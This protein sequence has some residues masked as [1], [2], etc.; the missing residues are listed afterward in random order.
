[1]SNDKGTSYWFS[2][3]LFFFT[4]CAFASS[5]LALPTKLS[6]RPT[7]E[8]LGY[9]LA[10]S[11]SPEAPQPIALA[12][13]ADRAEELDQL[14][15]QIRNQLLTADELLE[16]E[17]QTDSNEH[18]IVDRS[19]QTRELL[20]GAA[21]SLKLEDEQRYWRSKSQHFSSQRKD[22]TARAA[23]LQ[24]QIQLLET[25]QSEWQMTWEQIRNVQGIQA[26]ADRAHQ[27]LEKAQSARS[28][29]Q[30]QLNVVLTLQNRV[31]LEDQQVAEI[32]FRVRQ[33]RDR[34]RQ[35]IFQPD[36]A[37]LWRAS[38][39]ETNAYDSEPYG[40][41][42]GSL[43]SASE[44][45]RTH[46]LATIGVV[47][48]YLLALSA[49]IALRRYILK[50]NA[51][52][53]SLELLELL[54][55]PYS[56]AVLL[57]LIVTGGYVTSAP[58]SIAFFFYLLYA[59]PVL[60]LLPRMTRP[61]L[62]LSIY[63]T[64]CFYTLG[65]LYLLVQLPPFVSRIFYA[66]LIASAIATLLKISRPPLV[67][68]SLRGSHWL[69][70]LTLC[71]YVEF[72]ILIA[73]L[74]AN[75]AGLFSLS[76]LLG[77][78]ALVGPFFGASLY[79]AARVVI[80]IAAVVIDSPLVLM[81][82]QIH[83]SSAKWWSERI[84]AAVAV[85]VWFKSILQLLTVYEGATGTAVQLLKRPIGFEKMHF[86]VGSIFGIVV[87]MIGGY[88][89][90]K[91]A[92]LLLQT[93]VLP[94]VPLQRG[95]PYAIARITYY[96]LLLMVALFALSAAGAEL[97]KFTVLTGAMG[98]GLGFGL[99]NIVN[100][101]VSGIILLCERPIHVGDTVEIAGLVGVVRRIGARSSTILTFQG[102]E[103]IVPN[104][105]LLSDQVINWTLS[106][107]LR[108]VDIKVGVAYST[109]PEKVIKL[110]AD[111]ANS[112]PG[113]LMERPPAAFFMGFGENA[114]NFE[115]RFWCS[116]QDTWFQLQSDVT[117][118]VAKALGEAGIEIPFPQRDLH[119]RD[120]GFKG[121]PRPATAGARWPDLPDTHGETIH[122]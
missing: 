102:A 49:V 32:L 85:F 17:E 64:A 116:R 2:A 7:T 97:N 38:K 65:A 121:G 88:A 44:F 81:L 11:G 25:Q 66:L 113:V 52:E 94:R 104:S 9:A 14:I 62:R 42:E 93:V 35:R 90:A 57:G 73:S 56:M 122:S 79:C 12:Q 75:I 87:V 58:T 3:I 83:A 115:L 95:L 31:S 45:L 26:I 82:L 76:Q 6:L 89:L 54:R 27:Q 53:P 92:V 30:E 60:R 74:L 67:R 55:A 13:I 33:A 117:V 18:E 48:V 112:H 20:V 84:V 101:F 40:F 96:V 63:A 15:A 107:Q 69:H 22:L 28:Q 29:A 50:S 19:R 21:T 78:A 105:N 119:I 99:Q 118:A 36:T 120:P 43:T 5:T 86:T 34:D 4:L 108:R 100:N 91:T 114:L 10:A 16:L 37:P 51:T 110:L 109:D 106:S 59:L 1:M 71:V 24:Q 68:D 41:F 98:V 77:T 47:C 80:L 103:V 61:A 72:G 70:L 23:S 46:K 111:V 8:I 39:P